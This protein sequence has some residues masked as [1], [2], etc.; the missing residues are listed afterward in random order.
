[1]FQDTVHAG[2]RILRVSDLVR[3]Y[4][5]VEVHEIA[6]PGISGITMVGITFSGTAFGNAIDDTA[7]AEEKKDY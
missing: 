4:A 2:I 3:V 1:M 5:G 6:G 7:E